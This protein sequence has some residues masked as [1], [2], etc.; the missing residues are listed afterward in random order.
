MIIVHL[1]S[2]TF[3]GGPERQMLGLAQRLMPAYRSVF[4]SFSEK[5]KCRAF[6]N[7]ARHQGFD[8]WELNKDSPHFFAAIGEIQGWLQE[9]H[10]GV[11]C[12]HGYKANLLGRK[13]ARRVNVPVL[14]VSRG[15][16]GENL[17]VR[18]YERIDRFFLRRMDQVVCVSE[19]QS[20]K[21]RWAGVPAKKVTVIHNAIDVSRFAHSDP[22]YRNRLATLFRKPHSRVVGAAGRLSPEKG[23][24][25]LVDAARIISQ[26]DPTVGFVLFGEGPLRRDLLRQIVAA[27]LEETFVMPGFRRDLDGFLPF[28]DLLAVPSFTEGLPN[29]ILEAFAA[30]VPVVATAVGGTP[31]IVAN[32]INGL[33]TPAGDAPA[34]ARSIADLL[35]SEKKRRDMGERG[36][37]RVL[38]D[39]T[40]EAQATAYRRL[41]AELR[42]RNSKSEFRNSKSDMQTAELQKPARISDVEF[43]VSK[44]MDLP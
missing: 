23:F 16:T 31:E 32:E 24:S 5:G 34:L 12:C 25:I 15:W 26:T 19:G 28:I 2:S 44:E 29:V 37:Q 27:G 20:V 11:L 4:L 3:F 30:H 35:N 36:R 18:L 33:L 1:T 40:F 21:V 6:I 38:R 22:A 8:A 9:T 41:F 39:F 42:R 13:A 10:V 14:A 43:R 17:K 7:E